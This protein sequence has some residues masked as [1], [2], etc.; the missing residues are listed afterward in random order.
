[1]FKIPWIRGKVKSAVWDNFS[2]VSTSALNFIEWEMVHEEDKDESRFQAK[3]QT[4][5]I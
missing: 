2:E 4:L 3:G 5:E 1:M